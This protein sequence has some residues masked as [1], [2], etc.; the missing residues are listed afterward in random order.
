MLA[1]NVYILH[2]RDVLAFINIAYSIDK[3]CEFNGKSSSP[4][5]QH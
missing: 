3:D 2:A 5:P 4:D 1:G